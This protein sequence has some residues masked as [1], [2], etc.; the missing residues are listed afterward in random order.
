MDNLPIDPQAIIFIVVALIG[1]IHSTFFKKKKE[2]QPYDQPR[3]FDPTSAD[4]DDPL[5]DFRRMIEEARTEAKKTKEPEPVVTTEA[6]QLVIPQTQEPK[7]E[8]AVVA[9]PYTA[10]PVDLPAPQASAFPPSDTIQRKTKTRQTGE[11]TIKSL[12]SSPSASR[13]AI[14][15]TEI[16]GKPMGLR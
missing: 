8:E 11:L 16:L 1:F 5:R 12:L 13:K 10:A 14:I 2:E 3:P 15:L 9:S 7:Q 6:P 4:D